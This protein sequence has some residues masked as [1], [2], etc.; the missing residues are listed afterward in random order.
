MWRYSRQAQGRAAANAG[1][2]IELVAGRTSSD[3]LQ[4]N[5][6]E[7]LLRQGLL[8]VVLLEL[9]QRPR[10]LA[11]MLSKLLFPIIWKI[12]LVSIPPRWIAPTSAKPLQ[13]FS[14]AAG[15]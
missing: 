9:D 15:G 12:M 6:K 8:F 10:N 13:S 3:S 5:K 2:L 7:P 4:D 14:K 11:G 1:A